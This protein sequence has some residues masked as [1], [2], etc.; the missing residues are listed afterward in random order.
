MT[1]PE[2][3]GLLGGTF[4]PPHRG[5][6]ALAEAALAGG[7]VRH[8]HFVPSA[9]PPHKARPDLSDARHRL[10][11]TRLLVHGQPRMD[12]LDLELRRDGPSY[13]IDTVRDLY[14]RQRL[15]PCRLIIGWD[16]AVTFESWREAR[17]LALLAPPLVAWRPEPGLASEAGLPPDHRPAGPD[18]AAWPDVLRSI[19]GI[20]AA[21]MVLA[22]PALPVSSSF[23]R[24]CMAG[25]AEAS[26]EKWLP[27][28]VMR[29]I[30]QNGLYAPGPVA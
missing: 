21:D 18:F 13:T 24:A 10:E 28:E 27:P 16:M 6:L 30:A 3:T 8:V 17:N 5:H 7:Q 15:R 19:P 26:L 2:A 4:D 23:L 1:L 14:R 11:M 25:G 22:M 9:R 20:L 12:V 29:Y